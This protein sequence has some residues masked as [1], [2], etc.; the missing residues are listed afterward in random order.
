VRLLTRAV[1]SGLGV[2]LARDPLGEL[3][4]P[5]E[6]GVFARNVL[7]ARRLSGLPTA[8]LETLFYNDPR[9]FK[10][11]ARKDHSMVIGGAA[12]PYSERLVKLAAAL[13][14]GVRRFVDEYPGL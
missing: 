11:L 8:Y 14:S 7:I 10:A 4:T 5:V 13:A 3:E 2:P 6:P 12:Y 9:E 1:E